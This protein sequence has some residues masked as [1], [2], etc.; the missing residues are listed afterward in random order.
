GMALGPGGGWW[1]AGVA[2]VGNGVVGDER[3]PDKQNDHRAD[4]RAD[5]TSTLIEP[6]PAD[7]L[8]DEGGEESAGDPQHRGQ[9]ETL[10]IVWAR[11]EHARNQAGDEADHDDPDDVPHDDLPRFTSR[12]SILIRHRALRAVL[13]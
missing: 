1:P 2:R 11:R 6:V 5:K 8:A 3:V 13:H 7:G 12:R 9:E 4:G 10:R